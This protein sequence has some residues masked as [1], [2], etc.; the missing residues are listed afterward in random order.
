[1][2]DYS[3]QQTAK[4]N[5]R[6]PKEEAAR[7]IIYGKFKFRE[8]LRS[9]L[10]P[11]NQRE[12]ARFK[13]PRS[14]SAISLCPIRPFISSRLRASKSPPPVAPA[15]EDLGDLPGSY[16]A[17][18]LFLIARDPHWLFAY[19]DV[20]W[21]AW[22]S[23]AAEGKFFLKLFKAGGAHRVDKRDPSRGPQLVHPRKG[24]RHDLL[25]GTRLRWRRRRMDFHRPLGFRRHATG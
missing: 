4:G 16:G 3:L 9:I 22:Q 2:F 5:S 19:W 21:S 12:T 18:T 7:R 25:R 20:D 13:S 10:T 23:K 15:F 14:R 1:M 24:R 11:P 17:T 6:V 8:N